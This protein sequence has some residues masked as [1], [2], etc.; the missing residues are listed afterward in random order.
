MLADEM[1]EKIERKIGEQPDITLEDLKE[2]LS[3]PV[4]VSALCRTIDNKLEL[5]LKKRHSSRK[6]RTVLM[7]WHQEKSGLKRS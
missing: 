1:L 5:P 2:E 6:T 7:L 4:C 3:L